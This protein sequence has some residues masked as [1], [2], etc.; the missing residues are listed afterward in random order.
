MIVPVATDIEN[1]ENENENQEQI[2]RVAPARAGFRG[3]NAWGASQLV[4]IGPDTTNNDISLTENIS[5]LPVIDDD[6]DDDDGR[7]LF[8]GKSISITIFLIH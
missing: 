5:N 7:S 6:D 3:F 8:N 2:R 1:N 4:R